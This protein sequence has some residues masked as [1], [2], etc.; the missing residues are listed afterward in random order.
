MDADGST[1]PDQLLKLLLE[2]NGRHLIRYYAVIGSRWLKGS[3]MIEKQ[4]LRRRIASRGFNL[5]VRT[6]LGLPFRDTQCPAK[7]FRGDVI[8]SIAKELNVSDYCI[9]IAIL[10]EMK[11]RNYAVNEIPIVWQDKPLSKVKVRKMAPRA[12]VTML[13][14]WWNS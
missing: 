2:I 14:M 9:D 13:K 3:V 5:L 6:I 4:P 8:R 12:F 7:V 1:P 11:K 10:Y